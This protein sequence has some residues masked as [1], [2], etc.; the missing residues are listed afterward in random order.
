MVSV[1]LQGICCF[2]AVLKNGQEQL[3]LLIPGSRFILNLTLCLILI[4]SLSLNLL[5]ISSLKASF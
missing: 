3:R 5:K 4:L 2:M 1:G